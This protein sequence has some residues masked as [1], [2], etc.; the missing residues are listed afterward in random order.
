MNDLTETLEIQGAGGPIKFTSF[1]VDHGNILV[2]AIKVKRC[3]IHSRYIK[4]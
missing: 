2:S 4:S 3:S 1:D